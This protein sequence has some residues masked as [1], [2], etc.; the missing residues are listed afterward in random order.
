MGAVYL[1]P[2]QDCPAPTPHPFPFVHLCARLIA[3]NEFLTPILPIILATARVICPSIAHPSAKPLDMLSIVPLELPMSGGMG[4]STGVFSFSS[5][6]RRILQVVG[7]CN[8]IIPDLR[9]PDATPID[10]TS[11]RRA[12]GLIP[13]PIHSTRPPRNLPARQ[14]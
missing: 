5:I 7:C 12:G 3:Y 11:P 10:D 6:R 14:C 8:R 2:R 9:A 1:S 13:T 4:G